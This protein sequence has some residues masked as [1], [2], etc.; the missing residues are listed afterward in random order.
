MAKIILENRLYFPWR[1]KNPI[2]KSSRFKSRSATKLPSPK[3]FRS[4]CKITPTFTT[5]D[6]QMSISP[7]QAPTEEVTLPTVNISPVASLQQL[8]MAVLFTI[9]AYRR[10]QKESSYQSFSKTAP[11][12]PR[13]KTACLRNGGGQRGAFH[14]SDYSQ[15]P[16]RDHGGFEQQGSRRYLCVHAACPPG[17]LVVKEEKR[18]V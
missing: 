10:W 12:R 6:K 4:C 8:K 15:S 16:W 13:A 5:A 9:S 2:A 17:W 11:R 7:R 1:T 18:I 14:Q 3:R